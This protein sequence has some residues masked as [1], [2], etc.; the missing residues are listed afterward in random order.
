MPT[1][2]DGHTHLGLEKF[3]VKPISAEK[4]AKP[5]FRDKM[6]ASI[7][8]LLERMD[9]DGISR[10]V[11]F[12]YPLEEVDAEAANRY[13]FDAHTAHPD[14][15]IP[16]ALIGDDVEHWLEQGARGFKQHEILQA[17][18]RFNLKRA[19]GIM[20]NAGVPLI[21]HARSS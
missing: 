13:V 11:C 8:M 4:R 18:E 15:V 5:A 17:P 1:I 16:F 20:A 2:I 14:R 12:P 10:A 19:Y 3:I 7:E 21:I 6:E 9:A